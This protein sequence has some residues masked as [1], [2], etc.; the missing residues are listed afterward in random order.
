MITTFTV[1]TDAGEYTATWYGENA[2]VVAEEHGCR[3]INSCP[4]WALL[5]Q[6]LADGSV[7]LLQLKWN[8][9]ENERIDR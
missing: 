3:I 9:L 1:E 6:E 8:H 2:A 7:V 4:G 5:R